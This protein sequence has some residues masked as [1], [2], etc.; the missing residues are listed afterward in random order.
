[1]TKNIIWA[2]KKIKNRREELGVPALELWAELGVGTNFYDLEDYKEEP[3]KVQNVKNLKPLFDRLG[4]NIIDVF[5]I[6]C[7]FCC[8]I[9]NFFELAPVAIVISRERKKRRVSADLIAN[10][11]G[12]SGKMITDLEE[13]K[14]DIED[15]SID[16]IWKLAKKLNVPIQFLLQERC[17]RCLGTGHG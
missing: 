13:K 15:H 17:D 7:I 11:F 5:G 8:G 16:E 3:Y 4:L 9:A 6:R 14:S 10:S 1:M 2:H 12:Y